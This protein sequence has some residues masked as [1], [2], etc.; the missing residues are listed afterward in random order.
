M[1]HARAISFSLSPQYKLIEK[2]VVWNLCQQ[3]L[4]ARLTFR[5]PRSQR[6]DWMDLSLVEEDLIKEYL[7]KLELQVLRELTNMI[8]RT[9]FKSLLNCNNCKKSLKNGGKEMSLVSSESVRRKTQ[10]NYRL[11]SHT[12]M[13]RWWNS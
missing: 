11:V 13:G 9:L 5:N 3:S 12:S 1:V 10:K 7:S 8:V 6:P 2:A 4:P